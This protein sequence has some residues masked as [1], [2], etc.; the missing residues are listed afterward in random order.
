[1]RASSA[2]MPLGLIATEL[3]APLTLDDILIIS[4]YYAQVFSWRSVCQ[5]PRSEPQINSRSGSRDP[6][7]TRSQHQVT[8]TPP[9]HAVSLC[10][11]S[12][13]R[14]GLAR[15]VRLHLGRVTR[16]L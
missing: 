1:M 3:N 12:A 10:P 13:E 14:C 2:A 11:Q 16:R 15:E 6:S 5:A 7:F 8:Q 4:P 9:W